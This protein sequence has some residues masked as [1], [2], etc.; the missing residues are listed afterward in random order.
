MSEMLPLFST[1][2]ASQV[3]FFLVLYD[4]LARLL[5]NFAKS[6]TILSSRRPYPIIIINFFGS[7]V[8][9]ALRWTLVPPLVVFVLPCW[10]ASEQ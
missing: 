8:S 4:V 5:K 6:P 7:L 9:K 3:T 1:Q 2:K 10:L